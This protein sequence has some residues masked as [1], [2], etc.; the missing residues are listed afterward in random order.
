MT[1][2]K[3]FGGLLLTVGV[4]GLFLFGGCVAFLGYLALDSDPHFFTHL[5]QGSLLEILTG[6]LMLLLYLSIPSVFLIVLIILGLRLIK[7][8]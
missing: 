3:F 1:L 2:K 7:R 8:K 6:I 5:F 4:S